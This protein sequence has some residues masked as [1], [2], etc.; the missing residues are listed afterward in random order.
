MTAKYENGILTINVLTKK[1]EEPEV[2][3]ITIE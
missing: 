1:K 2:K 3:S